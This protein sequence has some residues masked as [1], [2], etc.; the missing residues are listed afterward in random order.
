MA[1]MYY[2]QDADMGL[3]KGKTIAVMG[4]GSQGHAQS[5]NLK[6]SGLNVIVGL[7]KNSP[8]W[9]EAEEAGLTVMTV[10]EAAAKADLIQI[11]LPDETQ[12]RIYREEIEPSL[13]AGKVLCFSHGFNIHFGQIVPPANVDVIMIAPKSPGHLVRRTYTEGAGTP[14]LIAVYQDAT[15]NAHQI[16]LAYA[17]GI[18]CT[19]T[20]LIETT[21]AEETETDLFGEQAVLC[22]GASELVRA[23][24]DT[25]VEAGYQPE[26]AYFECLHELKLI[27]DLMY[28]GGIS[29]MRYSVSDTAQYGDL[30][31]G[32]RIITEETRK[33]MKKVLSEIQNG[34]FAR[35]WLSENQVGRPVFNAMTRRDAEHK[36]E[37]VGQELRSMMPWLKKK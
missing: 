9:K 22:G 25:L 13:T 32:R 16:G 4:W 8:R 28:E 7:R 29:R 12:S 18:G 27:V 24:F 30:M 31:V 35:K 10:A 17:K 37:K 14:G 5:Q 6:D 19:R 33:E 26:I 36:I 34:E 23:G 20:G 15:G 2:D 21:F 3:L 1:K 11:L